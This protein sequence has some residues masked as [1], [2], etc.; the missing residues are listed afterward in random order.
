VVLVAD[1]GYTAELTL[2]E[3]QSCADCIVAFGDD[4]GFRSVM[5]GLSGKTQVK[6]LIEI[7][8]SRRPGNPN[9]RPLLARRP[10]LRLLQDL[11]LRAVAPTQPPRSAPVAS[12]AVDER[13]CLLECV[14]RLQHPDSARILRW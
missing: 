6:G 10:I 4:P 5:P 7:Q 12:R 13:F 2:A 3:V 14:K 1:D 8:S 11:L 9:R